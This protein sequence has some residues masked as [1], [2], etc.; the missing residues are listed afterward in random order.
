MNKKAV[1]IRIALVA[2]LFL[3]GAALGTYH[4]FARD[5]PSTARLE[6]FE[7]SLKTQVYADDGSLIGEL[8]EQN[9]VLIPLDQMPPA[10]VD[11][12]ISVEDRK[13]YSHWGI[14][15][16]GIARA[17]VKNIA[18]GEIVQGASTITQQLAR[19]LFVMF[20]VS[21]S[22]K[23]KE[24]I[25]AVKIERTYSKDEILEMYLNQI[26]FGSGA[27]GVEAAAREFFGKSV[28][29]LTIGESTLLAGLPKNPRDYSPHYH[30]DRGLVRRAVVLKAMVDAGKLEPAL[31]DSIAATEIVVAQERSKDP[32]AAYFLE[33]VRRYLETKYGADRI[34]HDG[35]QVYT[36]LDPY[37]QRIAEDSLESRLQQIERDHHYDQTLE[38]YEALL[39]SA[40]VGPPD[41]LQSAA[42]AIDVQTGYVRVM[43][44]GRNFKH[45]NFN[46]VVQ[47]QRQPGS[48]FKPFIYISA[49]ENGYTPADIVLDAPIVLDLPNGDVWKPNNFSKR[50]AGEITLRRAL[51]KSI[52]VAAVRLLL[53][54]GPVSAISYA[55]RLGV[56]SSLQSVYSLALGTSEV[57]LLELTDAYATLA[58]GG[59]RAEPLFVK[60]V[61]DRNGKILEENSVFREEALSPQTAY[62]ITNMLESV[63]NEGTGVGARLMGFN[64]PVAGKTGTTDDY[65]DGWFVGYTPELAVGVWTGFDTKR[66]MGPS[67]TGARTSLPLWTDIMKAYHPPG[68]GQPFAIPEGIVYRVICEDSGALSAP[69]CT[70]VRREVFVDGTEP[71]G[72]CDK[73]ETSIDALSSFDNYENLERVRWNYE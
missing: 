69:K 24:A 10:L 41:Y 47:A 6:N 5:L 54:L 15:M 23:V 25:L 42:V 2:V 32:F 63:V 43:V 39:D 44:G 13:F 18:A 53:S 40:D 4:F 66:T 29:E 12:I 19:N 55:H 8:Y 62:M 51:N 58:A 26:Y 27:Y 57:N 68:T 52:N 45:S 46:R 1:P 3:F 71:R 36:T 56:K 33:H 50:F 21:I 70:R 67:M 73:G 22:R 38:S 31:A 59:V 28:T 11:A 7:P 37:L 61:I 60:Q 20:D 35:L 64:E 14:D 16:F 49:L 72:Y 65:T 30:L 48:A 9:R 34:Y 17:M